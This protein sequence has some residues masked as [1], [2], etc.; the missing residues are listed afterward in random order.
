MAQVNLRE[1]ANADLQDTLAGEW[2]LP[3]I[4]VDPDGEEQIYNAVRPDDE[5]SGQ[6]MMARKGFDPNT[7]G[8][9][10]VGKPVVTLPVDSLTRVPT[11]EDVGEW[12]CR[13]PTKPE[14]SA[15]KKTYRIGRPFEGGLGHSM[16]RLYLEDVE[17]EPES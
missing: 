12:F 6:V 10:V 3:V 15:P 1:L 17:Q 7:G 4:L 16:I 2:S 11:D 14:W 13:A 9:I 5:L 8:D